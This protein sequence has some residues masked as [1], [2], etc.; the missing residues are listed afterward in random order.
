MSR[1]LLEDVYGSN[2]TYFLDGCEEATDV[3]ETKEVRKTKDGR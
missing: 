3:L 2:K 1:D